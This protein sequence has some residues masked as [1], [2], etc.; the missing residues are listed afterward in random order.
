MIYEHITNAQSHPIYIEKGSQL[1]NKH[2]N[3]ILFAE[4]YDI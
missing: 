4:I 3:H 2:Q 1:Q